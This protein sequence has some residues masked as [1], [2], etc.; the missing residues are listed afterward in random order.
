MKTRLDVINRAMRRLGVKAEDEALTADQIL[1]VGE[2]L[3]ALVEEL[4]E[5]AGITWTSN[6]VPDEVFVPLANLLAAHVGPDYGIQTGAIGG[7]KLRVLA[8]V[9]PD[10]RTDI[11]APV[12]Y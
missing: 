6:T 7:L 1:N 10:D 3:D 8:A 2:V 12:L 9:R 11:A 4:A 5:D